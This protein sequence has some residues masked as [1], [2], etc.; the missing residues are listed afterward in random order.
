MLGGSDRISEQVIGQ[1]RM[2]IKHG[3]FYVGAA[4]LVI[5]FQVATSRP[6]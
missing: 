3:D 5:I 2:W 6:S 1:H 4:T